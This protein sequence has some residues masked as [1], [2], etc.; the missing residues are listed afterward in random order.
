MNIIKNPK[1]LCPICGER[2][3][4]VDINAKGRERNIMRCS[5]CGHKQIR[6]R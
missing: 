3:F 1:M 2:A 5:E 6:G 4:G